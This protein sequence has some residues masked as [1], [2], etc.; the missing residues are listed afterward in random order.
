MGFRGI[1]NGRVGS[2]FVRAILLFLWANVY[3]DE[4]YIYAFISICIHAHTHIIAAI[5][6]VFYT[7]FVF[8]IRLFIVP[9]FC[10]C[11]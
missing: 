1:N 5:K 11:V 10:V 6:T 7:Y 3:V 9:S 8:N 4:E 2:I